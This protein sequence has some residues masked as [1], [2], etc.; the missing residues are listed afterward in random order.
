MLLL[1]LNLDGNG[2]SAPGAERLF[3]DF[4]DR[5]GLLALVLA[6]FDEF[7]DGTYEGG[8]DVL[9][10]GDLLSREVAFDVRLEDG[11]EDIVGRERVGVL[12][13]GPQFG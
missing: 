11:V 6:L 9:L 3:R 2:K 12:L 1:D 7:E 13:P 8:V 5:G 4:E 10:L